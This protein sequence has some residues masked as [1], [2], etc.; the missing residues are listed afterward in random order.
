[1]VATESSWQAGH[2]EEPVPALREAVKDTFGIEEHKMWPVSP[3]PAS[4][5]PL[6]LVEV[7]AEGGIDS[8]Q[9][10]VLG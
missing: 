3:V 9:Y 1:M 8:C 2:A 7:V 6:E 4:L 10:A 5:V